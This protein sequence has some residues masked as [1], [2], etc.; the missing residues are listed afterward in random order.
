MIC[1]GFL[2]DDLD[3]STLIY[4][5]SA[6]A[7]NVVAF[8]LHTLFLRS[9]YYARINSLSSKLRS[10]PAIFES[11]GCMNDDLIS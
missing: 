4:F 9:E 10:T 11:D 3:F 5:L 7:L 1:A 6:G 2:D 8:I